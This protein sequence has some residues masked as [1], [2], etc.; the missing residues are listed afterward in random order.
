MD[1]CIVIGRFIGHEVEQMH[2][3]GFV[4]RAWVAVVSSGKYTLP[5][6]AAILLVLVYLS[7]HI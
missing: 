4:P 5:F 6:T 1:V 7:H 2:M 3:I